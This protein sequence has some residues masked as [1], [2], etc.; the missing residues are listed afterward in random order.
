M[1]RLTNIL[2]KW[3][4]PNAPHDVRRRKL[5]NFFTVLI[6]SFIVMGAVVLAIYLMEK[7][8]R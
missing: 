7:R 5:Q 1:N 6:I 3:L 8:H 2:G 4:F